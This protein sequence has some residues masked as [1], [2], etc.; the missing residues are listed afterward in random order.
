MRTSDGGIYFEEKFLVFLFFEPSV[1]ISYSKINRDI[2]DT[3]LVR[4][5]ESLSETSIYLVL[6]PCLGSG[7]K[8]KQRFE[9]AGSE[10]KSESQIDPLTT[11]VRIRIWARIR[12]SVLLPHQYNVSSTG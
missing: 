10:R 5:T 11:S 7:Y 8:T 1:E 9:L 2:V 12:A 4:K 3:G 6:L